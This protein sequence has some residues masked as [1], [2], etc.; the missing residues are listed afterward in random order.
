MPCIDCREVCNL[1]CEHSRCSKLCCEPCDFTP[2]SQPC[3]LPLPR[4]GH[5]CLGLCGEVCPRICRICRPRF[6]E[7]ISMMRLH[8]FEPEDRFVQLVDCGHV[9]EVSGLDQWMRMEEGAAIQMEQ[10]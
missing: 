9:F 1:G 7:S 5:P 10:W 2:C 4:C 8:E 3:P 6:K